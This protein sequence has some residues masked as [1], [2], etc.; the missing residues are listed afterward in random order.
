MSDPSSFPPAIPKAPKALKTLTPEELETRTV[1]EESLIYQKLREESEIA[2]KQMQNEPLREF[3]YAEAKSRF[4]G[5]AQLLTVGDYQVGVSQT[6]GYRRSME[7]EFVAKAFNLPKF[8]KVHLFAVLDGHGGD[9]CVKFTKKL[10]PRQLKETLVEFNPKAPTLTGIFNA[11]KQTFV[12]VNSAFKTRFPEERSGTVGTAAV[13]IKGKIWTCNVGDCRTVLDNGGEPDALSHDASAEDSRY[14]PSIKA[15][16]GRIADWG[17][18]L[19]VGGIVAPARA[20]GDQ[21]VAGLSAR[22][23]ITVRDLQ[24]I[25]PNSQLHLLSDGVSEHISSKE[26][27]GHTHEHI[28]ERVDSV[29]KNIIHSLEDP[30]NATLLTVR[31]K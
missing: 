27:V 25:R 4:R 7:D 13:I 16:G 26:L 30:E 14:H 12:R 6:E 9:R 18:G 5:T 23:K 31:L 1:E 10:L 21:Y 24:K 22:G 19:R 20:L 3:F 2:R 15:L 8:G 17:D 11:L 29:A 28:A